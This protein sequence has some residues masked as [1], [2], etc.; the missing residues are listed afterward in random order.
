MKLLAIA[1]VNL[2][3]V[4]RDRTALFFMFLLPLL[5]ILILGL[6]F[7]GQ[8]SAKLGVLDQDQGPLGRDL[9]QHLRT[10]KDVSVREYSSRSGLI[11]DVERSRISGGIVIPEDYSN[12]IEIGSTTE[13]SLVAVDNQFAPSLRQNVSAALDDQA[14]ELVAGQFAAKQAGV[15]FDTALVT[16]RQL[17]ASG[18]SVTLT[19]YTP[20]QAG[21]TP[22]GQYDLVASQEV[23]LMGFLVAL[24]ASGQLMITRQLGISR[25]ML[26]TPTSAA[27]VILGEAAGRFL[28]AV[29]QAGFI[30]SVTTLAFGVRWGDPLAAAAIIGLFCLVGTGAAMLVGSVAESQSQ[31]TSA[32]IFVALVIAAIG[33]CMQPLQ[34]FPSVMRTV[35]H[36]TPHAWAL[37]AFDKTIRSDAGLI[38][39]AAQLGVLA[40]FAAVLLVLATWR[41]RRSL[42]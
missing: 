13:V 14:V 11:S 33:G 39:V 10:L 28:I 36:V 9:V 31:A 20:G 7:G 21:L 37:D 24:F 23:L 3:R 22:W 4:L 35:A 34:T 2:R 32:S 29:V 6:L 25:R 42:G 12:R 38:G 5:L 18:P 30:V 17:R 27:T 41:F 1:L 8:V 40:G 15:P 16:A 26:S 19:Q